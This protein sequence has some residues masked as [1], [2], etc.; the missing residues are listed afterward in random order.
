MGVRLDPASLIS[1]PTWAA[2]VI[3]SD[4][5]SQLWG[6]KGCMNHI[7]MVSLKRKVPAIFSALLFSTEQTSFFYTRRS[8]RHST[9]FLPNLSSTAVPSLMLFSLGKLHL[10]TFLAFFPI[11]LLLS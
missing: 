11:V 1:V 3:M 4:V 5:A 8:E 10:S 6:P 7:N 9:L 2:E